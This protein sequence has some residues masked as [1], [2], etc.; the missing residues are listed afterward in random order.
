MFKRILVP[1]DGSKRSERAIPVAARIARATGGTIV[2][3]E[4]VLPPV[5]FGT[6]TGDRTV[7]LKP[8]AFAR[9][10]EAGAGYLESIR[11]T[12]AS[13]LTGINTELDLSAG[14]AAPEIYE[15]AHLE[16]VDQIVLC[17]HGETGLKRWAFGS[18]AQEAVRHSPVP[19]LALNE[20]GIIP[21]MPDVTH[22]LR[23]LVP[24]DGSPLA[25]AAILP[26][27]YLVPA[28]SASPQ[29]E[30]HLLRVV[31]LPSAYGAMKSQAHISDLVHEE[32]KQEAE[33]YVTSV[34]ERTAKDLEAFNLQVTSSMV[35]SADVAGAIVHEAAQARDVATSTGYDLIAMA[36]HGRGGLLR[37]VMGS[38]TEHV[39]GATTLPVF[40]V[41]PRQAQA[42]TAGEEKDETV[43]VEVT[44]V[45]VQS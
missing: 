42:E 27:A 29:G 17:S 2:F 37:L 33:K 39:L 26:A 20:H 36:T 41:R 3:L 40:I 13:E 11:E 45:E 28:L 14:A 21:P 32:A 16:G 19:V 44:E 7:E 15:A 12:Y 38:V 1:L 10:E 6:Y 43:Q 24:L 25:E 5:E 9:R 4:V 34:A 35:D 31:A 23:V 18:I 30:L 8:S 22:P